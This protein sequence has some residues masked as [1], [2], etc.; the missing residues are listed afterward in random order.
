M[1]R[2]MGIARLERQLR[3]QAVGLMGLA[4]SLLYLT[5]LPSILLVSIPESATRNPMD[6]GAEGAARSEPWIALEHNARSHTCPSLG[7]QTKNST[8]MCSLVQK[9][10]PRAYWALHDSLHEDDTAHLQIYS[11]VN[12]DN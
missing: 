10:R 6:H 5:D 2:T 7:G 11:R 8:L 3:E 4:V 12:I 1:D 9:R